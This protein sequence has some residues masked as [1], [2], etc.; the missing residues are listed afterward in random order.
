[1]NAGFAAPDFMSG[2]DTAHQPGSRIVN[3]GL[4]VRGIELIG[5]P[6]IAAMI[7]EMNAIFNHHCIVARLETGV[8]APDQIWRGL[9]S[10][11]EWRARIIEV[12]VR[13]RT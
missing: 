2:P 7:Q 13:D 4:V 8:L 3:S 10:I 9:L 11:K 1:M 12:V 6:D 5:A